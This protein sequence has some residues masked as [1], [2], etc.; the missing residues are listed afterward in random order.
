MIRRLPLLAALLLLGQA[1]THT[2]RVAMNGDVGQSV[3]V[4]HDG[5]VKQTVTVH[6]AAGKALGTAPHED[7]DVYIAGL[8]W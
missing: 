7:D 2:I 3:K 1:N 5:V 8:G 4:H 6:N